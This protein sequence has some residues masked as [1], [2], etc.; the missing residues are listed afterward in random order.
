MVTRRETGFARVLR[1]L[2]AGLVIVASLTLLPA[3]P[4][5]ALTV[6]PMDLT[7]NA[8]VNGDYRMVGNGVLNCDP[9]RPTLSGN[10]TCAQLHDATAQNN[11]VNDFKWM[12]QV[13]VD[14]NGATA[15]SSRAVVNIPAGS[16]V[17]KAVLYWS[18]NTGNYKNA[19]GTTRVNACGGNAIPAGNDYVT[20]AGSPSTRDVT[21][22]FGATTFN[23]TPTNFAQEALGTLANSNP[24]Y[25]SAQADVTAQF[26]SLPAGS[27]QTITVGN[28]WAMQGYG[29][30]AGWS[31]ALV[32]DF[33]AFD[34]LNAVATNARE[35]FLYDGH[36]RKFAADPAP[37]V[38]PITGFVVQAAGSRGGFTLHE[39]DRNI[40]GD[41]AQ[42]QSNTA[43]A[44][45][46]IQN[47]VGGLN[48]IGV[49]NADGSVPYVTPTPATF[50]NANTD[51]R[52]TNLTGLATGDTSMNFSLDTTGDSYLMQNL[53][54]SVPSAAIKID[55]RFQGNLDEQTVAVG[56]T[57]TF[58]ITV[59]NAG[60]VPLRNLV[61]TDPLAP[62]CNR[63][64]AGPLGVAPAAN[65]VLTYTCTGQ[66]ATE[67]FTNTISIDSRTDLGGSFGDDD[68][69]VVHVPRIEVTKA[70]SPTIVDPGGS[71]T[72]TIVVTN[73]GDE[74]LSNVATTDPIVPDCDRPNLGTLNPGASTTYTCTSNNISAGFTNTVNA[75]GVSPIGVG[76]SATD[77][78]TAD[79]R[80]RS[81]SIVKSGTPVALT[82][83]GQ[84]V[85]YSFLVRNTGEVPLSN[86][87]VTDLPVAPA[88]PAPTVTCPSTTLAVGAQMTCTAS[89]V[90]TQADADNRAITNT[91]RVNATDA[92]GGA[93][94][95]TSNQVV[96]PIN[97]TS[98]LALVKSAAPTTYVLGTTVTYT[99]RATNTG[100]SSLSNVSITDTGLTGLSPLSCTPAAPA[101]LA[102]NAVM[103]CTATKTM[104][105]AD[106]DAGAVLNTA[107]ATGTPPPGGGGPVTGTDN[108][109]VTSA[110]TA[111]IELN[112]TASPSTYTAGTVVSYQFT[113]RNAGTKTLTNVSITDTGLTGL[114]PLSCTPVAPA[115]LAPNETMTCTATKTMTQA[116]A[117]AGAVLNTATTTGTPP[118]GAAPI[119]DT[120]NET[121]ISSAVAAISLVKSASPATYN[122]GDVVT[123]TFTSTNS[124]TKTLNG[125]TITDTGLT[126][127][128]PLSCTPA[129]PSSLA[130]N[131]TMTCTATKTM[132]QAEADAGSVTNTAQTSGTPAG[133]G[134]PVSATDNETVTS[135]ATPAIDLVKSASPATYLAGT[136]V[137]YT[138][139]TTNTG[140]KTL[141]NVSVA[142]SGLTGLS[143][144][145]CTP[146]APATLAPNATLT[147][148][149][150]K[151]A[152]QVEADAGAIINTA[153]ATGTPVGTATPIEDT[154]GETI[155]SAAAPAIDLVK[156]ASP[157]TYVA[158]DVVTYTF[159]TTNTGTTTLSGVGVSDTGLTGLSA[160]TCVPAAPAS[161]APG[162]IQTCTA[163]K[164]MTQ[165]ETD[166]GSVTNTAT[167]TGTPPGG[168][169][170]VTD[171]D[172]ETVT[173]SATSSLNL[174]KTAAPTTFL[175]GDVLT[176]T[177]VSTNTGTTSLTGVFVTDTGLAGLS[178]LAC[179]PASPTTLAPGEAQTCTATKTLT[180]A[181]TDAGSLT[182]TATATGTPPG[183]APPITANDD[184]T[185]TSSGQAGITLEKS[186]SPAS[187]I[188]GDDITY[189]F[190]TTNSGSLTLS[191]VGVTDT[192]LTGLSALSCTPAAPATL[193]PGEVQ[194]CT[195]TKTATQAE[196]DAGTIVNTAT[197]EG[198]PPGGGA[199]VTDTDDVTVTSAGSPGLVLSKTAAPTSYVAG[200]VVTYTFTATNN[201]TVSLSDVQVSD[202]GLTG[203]SALDCTPA[204]P[205]TLAPGEVLTCTA[206][207][208]MNQA[209]TDAG[210]VTNT[211][212]ATG[213]P[214][215]GGTP[216]TDEDDETVES[217]GA[218]QFTFAKTASPTTYLS[219]DVV[220]YTF[221]T[222]N[223]GTVSL[224]DVEVSDTGLAGL[225]ALSCTPAAPAALAP[226]EVQTCTA[227]KTMTQAEAD[228]G[229][230]TNTATVTV[231]PPVGGP[232]TGTDDETVTSTGTPA[233]SLD[234]SASPS[235]YVAGDVVTYTFTTT[236]SG[237]V[238]LSDVEVSDTALTGLSAL[239]CT[240][241]APATLAPGEVLSCTATKT[242]TQAETDAGS[243]LNTASATGTPPGGAPPVTQT[244]DETVTSTGTPALELVKSAS[245]L[246]YVAGDVVTYTF[247]N[248]NS[249]TVTLTDVSVTDTGLVG[250]S[251]L[252]CAPAAPA[253]LAPGDVQTC[254]ATKTMTQAE[255]DAGSVTNNAT[256]TGTPPGGG[257][258]VTGTD[259]ETITGQGLPNISL[260]KAASP[261]TYV[262]GD[263]VTYTFTTTNTGTVTLSDVEVSD[264]GLTGLSALDCTPAAPATLAPGETQTCTAT[265]TMTQAEAD[266]GSV[267]NSATVTG[268]PPGGGTPVTAIDDESV[269]SAGSPALEL[270]KSATPSTY[271]ADDVVTYTFT[272]T[273]T[274]TV[275]LDLVQVSD[276]G[277]TGLSALDCAPAAPATLA[278]GEV[279]SCTATKT[280]TQADVDA[281]AVTNTATAEGTPPGGGAPVTDT[282]DETVTSDGI[283]SISLVK[284]A[285][286]ATYVADDVV[287]YTFTST[288]T[289]TVTLSDVSVAD[290]GLVG[291]SPLD[292]T[293]AAPATLA[294][295][296]TQTCTATKTMT[297]AETDAGSVTNTATNTGTPPGGGAPVTG[298]DDETVTSTGSAEITLAK[299]A[300]PSTYIAGDVVTYAFTASNTGTLTLSDVS[301][302][303]TGL[304]GLSALDCTPVAPATL[305]PG[306]SITCTA[307]KT[308][309]QAEADAGSVVNTAA[310]T[311][312][313][314]GGG[315]PVEDTDDETVTS[316]ATGAI[317]LV[318][319]A[320]PLT[321]LAGDEV[322]YTFVTTNSGTLTLSDVSVTDTGLVGLSA[323][324]CV[325]AAP[326]TLAPGETQTCTATKTMT[327]AEA[328]AGSVVNTA[329]TTGTPPGGAAP[330]TGTDDE[331]VTSDAAPGIELDK[332]ALPLT[333]LAGDEVTYTFVTT[334]TGT[335]TLSAVEVS[336]TGLTGLSALDCTPVSPATLA[337]GEALTCTATK[338][339]TQAEVDAGSVVNVA[340]TTGT[341]PGGGAAVTDVDDATVTSAGTPSLS[342]VK[343]A[344]PLTYLADDVVTYTFV[345][346]NTGTLTLSDVAVAD[347]GLTGLSALD[348]T[349]AAP[350]T[351]APGEV[352]TCTA[353]KTMTQAETDAGSVTNTATATGTPPGGAAPVTGT[354]DETVTSDGVAGISLAKTAAP[355]TYL[356]DDVVT[357]T[358]VTTNTGSLTLSDVSVA[359]TGLV[360]LSA[361]D[362]APAA[363]ATLAPGE[364]Q[365]CTATKTMTQAEVDA[366]SVV[367]TATTTGTPPG[368]AAPVTATDDE[369]LTSAGVAEITLVKAADPLTYLAGDVVTYTFTTTNSGTLTLS[370][371]EV[372][373]TGLTGL[374][375]L[376]CTP[377]APATLAPGE[378]QTCSATKTMTQAD[379][380]AGSVTNVATT[381]GTPPGGAAAV[382][383]TDDETVTGNGVPGISLA[384]TADPATY[385]A[386]DEITYTFVTTNT[387]T[388]TLS[389]VEVSDAGLTGLSALDCVPAAPATL[390][391]AETQ[392]CTA[393]KTAT[394]AE[395]DA[396]SITNTAT[397][398]G[399]PP[400][401]VA[402]VTATD[403]ETVT[404]IAEPGL[405]L[406]KSADPTTYV[407][408]D[409]VTYT[410]VATNSGGLTL[411]DVDITDTGLTGLSALDCTPTA[412][413]S[414]APGEDLTC[415]ATKTMSQAETDAG[416]V[417]N[418]ATATGTPPG[419]ANP[420]TATD[421]ETVLS[422]GAG[423]IDLV[424]SVSPGT[425]VAGDELTYTFE[426][427]NTGGLTLTGVEIT[428]TGLDGLSS[429]ECT[430][431]APATLAPGENLTCTATK[432]ATQAETDA[433]SITNTATVVGTPPEACGCPSVTDSA[434]ATALS[435]GVGA[436]SLNKTAKL[437]DTDGNGKAN[438]GEVIVYSFEVTNSGTLTLTSVTVNDPMLGGDISCTPSTLAPQGVARCGPINY[439]VTKQDV[440][441]GSVKN[442]ATASGNDGNPGTKN[443][444]TGDGTTTPADPTKPVIPETGAS[445]AITTNALLGASLLL[446]GAL[447]MALGRRR[448]TEDDMKATEGS[449]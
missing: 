266:A 353:T 228:A 60:G 41:F 383:D 207:K 306:E 330:V 181:D 220:T 325:P 427:T 441:A 419:G 208:T 84:T 210:S 368:G 308:M 290:S 53:V 180:Q 268:T 212:T 94:V 118:A 223:T 417:T 379:V 403:D 58:T 333:Y 317:T 132:T 161:L 71:T 31:L 193:A 292:C 211:A 311:G 355:L 113:T 46:Q 50:T 328:D 443:P 104:T 343:T 62:N 336:D 92:N 13:D 22:N 248:T 296:E 392:T 145:S 352:Q 391:P 110:A 4:A 271:L 302:T 1:R 21:V 107:T 200:D 350:A 199:P 5:P 299:S 367:N 124:G 359:D 298:T 300:D 395:T 340:T 231:T 240:P 91:A 263:V 405:T 32:Y 101:T 385:V 372:S 253:I 122:G 396:G 120:D 2:V 261:A 87:V 305:A 335:Q 377:A 125:V 346:T 276:S 279:L 158:G 312:T 315:A 23:A 239:D 195:A 373:D 129:A 213:T 310:T 148:T 229:A 449:S 421:D 424:K 144:L 88:A 164:T 196:A 331:T 341:P 27:N 270:T 399:T 413:A 153:R 280:M 40:T 301:V 9:N 436:L 8:I 286:P 445:T 134:A 387:G 257:A 37:E 420:V 203:L 80:V 179:T 12:G 10:F 243:V 362:C 135:S 287:T 442:S 204:A 77:S 174:V 351:L 183:G 446:S 222:T 192:G 407:A 245:P 412:P 115:T 143:P 171:T 374:S 375:A 119:A 206:T 422:V 354:D 186:A 117:D 416:S 35:I 133:G 218:P 175:T 432:T 397:T 316:A 39:G 235:T 185:V 95:A 232:L 139:T 54:L 167:N 357:Y 96:I 241:A 319:T 20:P 284:T 81:I 64:I 390:A 66:P 327:Q 72:W 364:T 121:V 102:P 313:P 116:E 168:G 184:E 29:C 111:A 165:A 393:S 44:P 172:D 70:A 109:T 45:T 123:F 307:T 376:D 219:G 63:N 334:N 182:N 3:P 265:K 149:A 329:T 320:S 18:G 146:A 226:G 237:S 224:S 344:D 205:A 426:A 217:D 277:L 128:S 187:Y 386:G 366:G 371:V 259:D 430:P 406:V 103:T 55:K 388:L 380:D 85:N 194:T 159:T 249:G 147:C 250:L 394:Q 75:T 361:L 43:A 100:T 409:E 444:T 209:E 275:T 127:L 332:T 202:T 215:G 378:T 201:G 423:S 283:P 411:S 326:A 156:G 162:T 251:A 415:T 30:Y 428:D 258:P 246:T 227:T 347:A 434:D 337:P 19:N 76:A 272:A 429:L 42:Y 437:K 93:T 90:A 348:C 130:P 25:Y 78:A 291:L 137:T 114:S 79:V 288:N 304:V 384:K 342:L 404:S 440:A 68:T 274:G 138:F 65:S 6:T 14:A 188:A 47:A 160:L 49:S 247:T 191:G 131:E 169:A 150:T 400:G 303:D 293:P 278:P 225:S 170:S 83:A 163:T 382:T 89:Y 230:V 363:P 151:T 358:F 269:T 190:V 297:Q 74:T 321:Y 381:T 108:E 16:T 254:T 345:T 236:N 433:G 281:G 52:N 86:V 140:T 389:D 99:F 67:A 7:Y 69:S 36:V 26:A 408:G 38:I 177:F 97:V 197:A 425:F 166:A 262:A 59:T 198:T 141:N 112:K 338:T 402:P 73:I 189:T 439:T 401:G 285:A 324:D 273:N 447:F 98:S 438:V 126:G 178:A 410:F 294:P 260:V 370:D 57:P 267:T 365:T 216:V 17:V 356:A 105:Q 51:V 154:D 11:L 15:N 155:T 176:Y 238:T 142:D 252:D 418:T 282:D 33:G 349:P 28:L 157:A 61:I 244:D 289:G 264:T 431:A 234:K 106:A 48:N 255:T 448:R 82:A 214:P 322:T 242:M 360:G 221:T 435:A 56:G 152:S 318:K 414:L 339:M 369:T 24:Q 173:S 136:V 233:L 295:G 323:L 309:T 314:P 34:P 398:T 256:S